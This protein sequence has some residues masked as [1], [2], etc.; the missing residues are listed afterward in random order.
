MSNAAFLDVRITRLN[1]FVLLL[2]AFS[3]PL[4]AQ[5]TQLYGGYVYDSLSNNRGTWKEVYLG[6]HQKTDK[7]QGYYITARATERF[8][9]HDNELSGGIYLPVNPTWIFSAEA[10]ASTTQRA[11]PD[12][13]A[14]I[15]MQR[16]LPAGFSVHA[17]VR[18][19]QYDFVDVDSLLLTGEWYYGVWRAAY[20][21][22]ATQLDQ[23]DTDTTHSLALDHYYGSEKESAIG[24]R[25]VTG[26]ESEKIDIP[27]S[28]LT[29]EV[30]GY[31]VTGR[32]WLNEKWA[33]TY[34]AGKTRQDDLYDRSTYGLGIYYRF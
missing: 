29:M 9:A 23:G 27:L 13:T 21:L 5:E 17:G 1:C 24:I 11:L 28:V 20:T 15:Q 18:R 6:A 16:L 26:T 2:S 22:G 14:L 12:W 25:Y 3:V 4:L 34:I 31:A 33:V 19:K 32:H 8:S 30:D 7:Y 10:S